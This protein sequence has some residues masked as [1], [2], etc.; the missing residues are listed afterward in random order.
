MNIPY[1]ISDNAI[2]MMID[3]KTY[4]VNRADSRFA[5]VRNAIRN[6]Q[7][8]TIPTLLDL[9]GK[10]VSQSNGGL[11]LINGV[12]HS[13]KYVIPAL[14]ASRIV[15]MLKEGFNCDP[16]FKFLENLMSNPGLNHRSE[17]VNRSVIDELYG[18]IEASNL[19]ITADGHFL[20]YKMVS[21]EYK[22]LHTHSMDNSVGAVVSM[23]RERV[24]PERDNTCSRGLHFCS[25]AYLSSGY[26]YESNAVIVVLKINPRDVVTI[27]SDYNNAKGRA[28]RY[29][30]VDS[31]KW[32]ER[33][34][35][36]FTSEY[37]EQ[38]NTDYQPDFNLTP[39]GERWEVRYSDT[40]TLI[41]SFDTREDARVFY[42]S[43]MN[44][45]NIFIWDSYRRDVV[46]GEVSDGVDLTN[47][48][49]YEDEDEDVA[50]AEYDVSYAEYDEDWGCDSPLTPSTVSVSPSAKLNEDT[51]REIRIDLEHY[52]IAGLAR[53]YD[54][55]ERT[56][57]RIRDGESWKHVV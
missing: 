14:L 5:D 13:D 34:K 31:L 4:V 17:S 15:A 37:T 21:K 52:T 42:R 48:P 46:R 56:I 39:N 43:M 16:L 26:A 1:T 23:P 41:A 30:I 53:K 33:I 45:A 2:T 36:D 7:F 50:Y 29:K 49:P 20:A 10:L 6:E 51:V 54:V 9:K 38:E 3:G 25:E 24:D 8:D 12:L 28:C 40:G 44:L 18:F 11:Y 55:S 57:R 35:P 22:D 47:L 27:P 19:P 32:E